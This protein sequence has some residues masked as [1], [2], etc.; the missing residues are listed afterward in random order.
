MATEPPE[1]FGKPEVLGLS[2]RD[3]TV[4][5]G[6]DRGPDQN[7]KEKRTAYRDARDHDKDEPQTKERVQ[8]DEPPGLVVQVR[9][10]DPERTTESHPFT[11]EAA[12]PA[13]K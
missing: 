6:G 13:T 5:H 10:C 2:E 11:P 12:T 9:G 1:G 3:R 7:G 4:H 8:D